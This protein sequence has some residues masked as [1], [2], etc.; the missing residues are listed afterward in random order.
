MNEIENQES[1]T[2]CQIVK[3][4]LKQE[5]LHQKDLAERIGK[6]TPA[7]STQLNSGYMSAE[8]FRRMADAAVKQPNNCQL[9]TAPEAR[10]FFFEKNLFSC[11]KI[12]KYLLYFSRIYGKISLPVRNT[13]AHHQPPQG[14]QHNE[15]S[16]N[17]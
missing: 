13:A 6:S 1:M 2:A 5:R 16:E 10:R 15:V 12:S 9:A 3:A 17:A 11:K 8:E 4:I 14:G 7:L